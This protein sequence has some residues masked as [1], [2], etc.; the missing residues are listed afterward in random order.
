MGL[1]ALAVLSSRRALDFVW[2]RLAVVGLLTLTVVD[3]P[4]GQVD[5]LGVVYTLTAGV[6]WALYTVTGKNLGSLYA[7]QVTSLGMVVGALFTVPLGVAQAG[8]ALFVPSLILVGFGIRLLSSATLYSLEMA[9]LRHLL[10]KTF[11]VLFGLEPVIGVLAGAIVL[12][13]QLTG[14]QWV[15]ILAIVAA[16]AGCALTVRAPKPSPNSTDVA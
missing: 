1:L 3:K 14:R 9:A 13:E 10:G 7:G 15:A 5:H 6:C 11:S 2:I 4:V 12:Y 8:S 16:L